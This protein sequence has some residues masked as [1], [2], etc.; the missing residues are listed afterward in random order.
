[1]WVNSKNYISVEISSTDDTSVLVI[2][3]DGDDD[4]SDLQNPEPMEDSI[5]EQ[6]T[7]PPGNRDVFVFPSPSSDEG[8]VFGTSIMQRSKSGAQNG[9]AVA[10]S[11]FVGRSN[12]PNGI[13]ASPD[14]ISPIVEPVNDRRKT[15]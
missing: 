7:I 8:S 13:V 5:E 10:S 1:M 11:P 6:Q 15:R 2:D 12:P 3:E 4:E 9:S 14:N